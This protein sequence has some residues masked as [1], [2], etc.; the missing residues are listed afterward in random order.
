MNSSIR[1]RSE[2]IYSGVSMQDELKSVL[3][4]FR[5][6]D[7]HLDIPITP[8]IFV[9]ERSTPEDVKTWLKAKQFSKR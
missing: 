2:S 1:S 7:K 9:N 3:E 4:I 5:E 6:R 8:E